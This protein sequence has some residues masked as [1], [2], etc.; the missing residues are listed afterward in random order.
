MKCISPRIHFRKNANIAGGRAEQKKYGKSTREAI[1]N[2]ERFSSQLNTNGCRQNGFAIKNCM[3]AI[4][5][6]F[7]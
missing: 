7:S 6:F 3:L 4:A 1:H 2:V 5:F